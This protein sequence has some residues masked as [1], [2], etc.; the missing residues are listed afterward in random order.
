MRIGISSKESSTFSSIDQRFGRCKYF[1]IV[2]LEGN[3]VKDTKAVE[4]QGAIQGHSAGIRF[5]DGAGMARGD[6]IVSFILRY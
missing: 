6:K 4:N 1:I 3:N 5:S 2:D